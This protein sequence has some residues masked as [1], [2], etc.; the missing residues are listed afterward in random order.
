VTV[1][2]LTYP[3]GPAELTPPYWVFMGATAISVLAGAQILQLPPSPLSAAVHAV[4][5]GL[6]VMLWAFGTWL[7]PLLV[8]LGVWRHVVRRVPLTYEPGMWSI[9]FPVGMYAV[10][11]HELGT[12]LNVSWLVTLGRDAAWPALATWTAVFVA[13]IATLLRR[14][15]RPAEGRPA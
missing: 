10:A 9:V 4:L 1:A 7:I 13:M 2:L 8:V 11:S 6:S 5:A 3:V 15:S 12:A 14:S